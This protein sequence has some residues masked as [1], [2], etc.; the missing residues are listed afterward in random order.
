M[1]SGTGSN[2][3]AIC[4]AEQSDNVRYHVTLVIASRPDAGIIDVAKRYDVPHEVVQWD[5]QTR[6]AGTEHLRNVLRTYAID[7]LVL[8]GFMKLLPVEIISDLHGHVLNIH[9]ALLPAFGGKGMYGIKVHEAVLAAG[10]TETGATVHLVTEEYDE[11]AILAREIV[12]VRPDDTPNSLQERV[13]AAEH[14]L[15]P[16][17]VDE[18]ARSHAISTPS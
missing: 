3:A 12:P 16:R 11:G 1:G 14:R 4:A 6:A 7:V 18:F 8:A 10:A 17:I 2:A 5:A 9:P 13:K 15:Y